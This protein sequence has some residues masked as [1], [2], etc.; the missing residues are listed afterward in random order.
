[1]QRLSE[2]LAS[3]PNP[4]NKAALAN[5]LASEQQ[6]L[7]EMYLAANDPKDAIEPFRQALAFWKGQ[8]VGMNTANLIEQLTT[9]LLQDA[10]YTAAC[11]FA[12]DLT[13]TKNPQASAVQAIIWRYANSLK[14]SGVRNKDLQKLNN[15][16]KLVN[17][18]LK[19]DRLE[20]RF[21]DELIA[22]EVEAQHTIESLPR[23][24]AIWIWLA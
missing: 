17:E 24:A 6:S 13:R 11:D 3:E 12:S 4:A 5:D 16:L 14:D 19:V 9:A 1:M 23:T 2:A 18:A 8:P 15:V 20:K 22:F 10:Q 21:R 7:G